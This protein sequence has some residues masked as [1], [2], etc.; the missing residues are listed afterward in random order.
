M[1]F[2]VP[3]GSTTDPAQMTAPV[4]A[5][6]T[7]PVSDINPFAAYCGYREFLSLAYA[8]KRFCEML[9]TD[10]KDAA[11]ANLR[12]FMEFCKPEARDAWNRFQ[13]TALKKRGGVLVCINRWSDYCNSYGI[14]EDYETPTTIN[15]DAND[16]D[17][18]L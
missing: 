3:A 18:S 12:V 17:F 1:T 4:S 13:K 14:P 8:G 16:E 15:G 11:V 7:A 10:G 6:A 9:S 2:D 5:S